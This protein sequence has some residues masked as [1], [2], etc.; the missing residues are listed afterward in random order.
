VLA[1]GA[2]SGQIEGLPR[3][4]PL[5]PVKGQM[6]AVD[7]RGRSAA[8]PTE[9]MLNRVVFSRHCYIIP[10]DDG[11]L[12]VGATMED[13][14]FRKGPTPRGIAGLMAAASVL[15]PLI[16]DLPLVETWAGFRPATPDHMPIIGSDPDLPGLIYATGHFR[17]GILLAPITAAC[18]AALVKGSTPPL[19]LEA[20]G[21]ERFR[22]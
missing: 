4:L 17:N 8:R 13:V 19:P 11:R 2:W 9:P 15:I 10:R 3:A 12:L 14:G 6:F 21:V 22:G 20:F 1:A 7:G 16:E 5:R 18:V